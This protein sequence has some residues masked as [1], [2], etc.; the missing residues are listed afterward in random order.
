MYGDKFNDEE[1]QDYR[2]K[3]Q[4]ILEINGNKL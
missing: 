3:V 1:Y 2:Q 4:K